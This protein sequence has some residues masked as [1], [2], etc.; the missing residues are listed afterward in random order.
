MGLLKPARGIRINRSHPLARNLTG[1]W[2]FNDG[3]GQY[4]YDTGTYRK[5]GSFLGDPP[6]W[7]PGLHGHCIQ[8]DGSEECIDI[9]TSKFGLDVT[10]ELSVVALVNQHAS[11]SGIIFARSAFVRPVKLETYPSGKFRF[12]VYTDSDDCLLVSSSVHATDGSEWCHVAGTWKQYDGRIYVNGSLENSE[13]SSNG[14]LSFV[15]DSQPVGIG[16][17][18]EAGSYRYCYQGATEYV[19]IFNHVLSADEIKS[20]YR[21]P[22]AMFDNRI[23]PALVSPPVNIVPLAGSINAQSSVTGTLSVLVSNRQYMERNWLTDALFN[24][25][26]ANAIKLGTTLSMS[27]F[28]FRSAGCTVLYR[29]SGMEKINFSDILAVTGK[30][31]SEISPPCYISHNNDSTYFYVIRRFNNCGCEELTLAA[32]TKVSINNEGELSP[33]MPNKIFALKAEQVECNKIKLTWFYCPVEQKSQPVRF[34][35]Y[36]DG[37]TGRLDYENPLATIDYRGR[38]F[39][40]FTT[41]CLETGR[42]IFAVKVEDAE[43]TENN[44][45]AQT[46]IELNVANPNSIEILS[47]TGV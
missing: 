11:H 10:N 18:Y 34:N 25:M 21:E 37:G 35:I 8:F 3:A 9:G 1:C 31:V 16:G 4:V 15:S 6:L 17:T 42:Y 26:T 28:W 38:I 43:S 47:V 46:S 29:G 30:D 32:A 23:T 5:A 2:L 36:Y 7:K 12:Y 33:P 22:F 40:S 45:F 14:N 13:S 27:W 39:Y 19:F 20:L 44:S 24:G 41:D